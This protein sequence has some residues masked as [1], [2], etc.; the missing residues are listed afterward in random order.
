MSAGD[1]MTEFNMNS[2]S[3]YAAL[4]EGKLIGSRCKKCGYQVSPQRL[5]CPK[6][7]SDQMTLIE[8]SGEGKL[9]AYTVIYV[10]PTEMQQAGY[11]NKNPYCVGVVELKEGPRV[12][13]QILDLDLAQP[14]E[15]K[16]G[17]QLQMTSVV[18]ES[19]GSSQKFLAFKPV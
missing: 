10:P 11:N 2:K 4:N 3:F 18:R 7:H 14:A 17:I 15:I 12:N 6:C 13:A 8:F 5:I 9:A 16:I 1:K 19:K